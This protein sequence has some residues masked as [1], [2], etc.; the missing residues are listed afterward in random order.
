VGVL[1]LNPDGTPNADYPC[2]NPDPYV[3]TNA[4]RQERAWQRDIVN[5]RLCKASFT[6][7]IEWYQI[8]DDAIRDIDRAAKQSEAK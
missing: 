3:G 5:L 8:R 1:P 4:A 7:T 2:A 6:S